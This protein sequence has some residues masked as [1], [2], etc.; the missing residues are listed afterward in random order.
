M[1]R[2]W[3]K[4]A[5]VSTDCGAVANLKGPPVNTGSGADGEMRAAAMALMAGTDVESGAT[6]FGQLSKAIGKGLA[7]EAA[8][9][10]A[11]RRTFKMMFTVGRFDPANASEWNTFGLESI[12][13]TASQEANFEAGLQGQVLLR[14]DGVLPIKPGSKVAVVGPQSASRMGMLSSYASYQFCHGNQTIQTPQSYC[15]T[16]IEEGIRAA[17]VG[18]V[19]TAADGVD[20]NSN[21]TAGIAAALELARGADVVVLALGIDKS[22]EKEGT[23]RD[24]TALPGLQEPFAKQVLALDKPTVL[25]L[26]NGGALA[27]DNLTSRARN[28]TAPYAI[29]EAFNPNVL[30]ARAVGAALF[31]AANRW[32]KLPITIY[33]HSFIAEQQMSNYDMAKP[34]GRTYKYYTG[35]PLFPFGV[36]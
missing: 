29:V 3:K 14:N 24:D 2:S 19:T 10:A 4:D 31:G 20:I 30:G 33:P 22:I 25:L 34:P 1:L 21:A 32:G 12:N 35:E 18:G 23:D 26:T 8:L 13:S 36:K 6:L 17:N 11:V 28:E 15:I 27:I 7:T 16:T 5:I 9:D